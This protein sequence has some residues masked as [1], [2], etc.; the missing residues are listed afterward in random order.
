MQ[1]FKQC[2]GNS[3]AAYISGLIPKDQATPLYSLERWVLLLLIISLLGLLESNALKFQ[4]RYTFFKIY[5][6]P[7]SNIP[8][9]LQ[10]IPSAY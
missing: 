10:Y 2:F 1:L 5:F 8:Y 7:I 6:N 3:V 9:Q 4:V